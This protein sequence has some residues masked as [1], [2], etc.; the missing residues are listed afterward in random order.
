MIMAPRESNA[1]DRKVI[2][3]IAKMAWSWCRELVDVREATGV[4]RCVLAGRQCVFKSRSSWRFPSGYQRVC[5]SEPL[6]GRDGDYDDDGNYY[7]S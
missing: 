3:N 6:A 5:I 2:G 7:W 1:V 4:C